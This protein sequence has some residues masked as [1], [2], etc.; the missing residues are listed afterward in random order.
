[1]SWIKCFI[2]KLYINISINAIYYLNYIIYFY[3]LPKYTHKFYLI[4]GNYYYK[5][6]YKLNCNKNNTLLI[7]YKLNLLK[8]I[9]IIYKNAKL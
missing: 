7:Q 8:Y 9:K 1:M 5:I 3:I 6:Q 2:Y 4:K